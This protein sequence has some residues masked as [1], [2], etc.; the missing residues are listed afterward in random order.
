MR[1][2]GPIEYARPNPCV[3]EHKVVANDKLIFLDTLTVTVTLFLCFMK[4]IRKE[5]RVFKLR[6][7]WSFGS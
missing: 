7:E 1:A 5:N 6:D 4:L 3:E 2:V